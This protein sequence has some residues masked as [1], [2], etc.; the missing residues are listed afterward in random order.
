M[1][2]SDWDATE[3]IWRLTNALNQLQFNRFEDVTFTEIATHGTISRDELVGRIR[4]LRVAS[5]SEPSLRARS[6]LIARPGDRVTVEATLAM[7]EGGTTV[8]TTSFRVPRGVRGVH[9]LVVRGG[10]ERYRYR[11]RS[12]DQ[13]VAQLNGGEHPDDL[14]L[15]GLGRTRLRPQDVIVRGRQGFSIQIVR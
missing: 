1:A 4:Q 14:V 5:T 8:V 9:D 10:R 3:V 11:A 7:A 12:F 13:L 15:E 6:V 2:H